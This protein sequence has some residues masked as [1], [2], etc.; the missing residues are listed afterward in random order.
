MCDNY[1]FS[2]FYP[3][4]TG[5]KC[6]YVTELYFLVLRLWNISRVKLPDSSQTAPNRRIFSQSGHLTTGEVKKKSAFGF[7]GLWEK[8][9]GHAI[10]WG[11]DWLR[12]L[13]ER[14]AS[15]MSW[16][17]WKASNNAWEYV[18]IFANLLVGS[19]RRGLVHPFGWLLFQLKRRWKKRGDIELLQL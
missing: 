5:K 6:S 10:V 7:G 1:I 13:S 8:V 17:V 9:F 2:N 16:G 18:K 4:L 3:I 15:L 12:V 14:M 11:R 19:M